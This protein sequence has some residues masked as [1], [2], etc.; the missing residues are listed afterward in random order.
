MTSQDIA[1]TVAV[2]GGDPVV[3]KAIEAVI[4]DAGYDA[5]LFT[6]LPTNGS[7]HLLDGARVLLLAPGITTRERE[8]FLKGRKTPVVELVTILDE[9]QQRQGG[10]VTWPAGV[11]EI[12]REIDVALLDSAG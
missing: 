11:E 3:G 1:P 5:L 2:L 8:T 6:A 4:S 10:R 12:G 7:R 9:S